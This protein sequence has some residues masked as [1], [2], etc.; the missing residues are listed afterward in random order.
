MMNESSA[1]DNVYGYFERNRWLVIVISVVMLNASVLIGGFFLHDLGQDQ[2]IYSVIG[3]CIKAF[4]IL[5]LIYAGILNMMCNTLSARV[6]RMVVLVVMFAGF[7]AF[8]LKTLNL[9]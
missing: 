2:T 5:L 4:S 3:G 7:I 6:F 8:L 9:Y 1:P